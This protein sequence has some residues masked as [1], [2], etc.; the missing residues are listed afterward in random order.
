MMKIRATIIAPE[1][2]PPEKI[3]KLEDM[4]VTVWKKGKV[5]ILFVCV[6]VSF[7]FVLF[8]K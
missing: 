4:G 3:K 8:E 2:T 5:L 7:Y 1:D 6:F